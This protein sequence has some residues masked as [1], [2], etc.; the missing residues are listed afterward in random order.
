MSSD[1]HDVRRTAQ[2]RSPNFPSEGFRAKTAKIKAAKI[3]ADTWFLHGNL[4]LR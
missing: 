4:Q 1:Y 3:K 2:W